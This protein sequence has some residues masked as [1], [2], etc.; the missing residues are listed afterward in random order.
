METIC[1]CEILVY[2]QQTTRCDIQKDRNLCKHCCENLKSYVLNFVFHIRTACPINLFLNTSVLTMIGTK[3]RMRFCSIY[4]VSCVPVNLC[5]TQ[6]LTMHCSGKPKCLLKRWT[7]LLTNG[8]EYY[9]C[10][11]ICF[12]S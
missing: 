5:R 4:T 1:S 12:S 2:F 11:S 9:T 10:S 7:W 6:K 3:Y 8:Q